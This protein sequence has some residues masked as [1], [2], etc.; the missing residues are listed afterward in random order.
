[1]RLTHLQAARST[2]SSPNCKNNVKRRWSRLG[3]PGKPF[4]LCILGRLEAG[5]FLETLL[6][7]FFSQ[8]VHIWGILLLRST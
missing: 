1:V 5:C 7:G 3:L 2:A 8:T 4:K 6:Q